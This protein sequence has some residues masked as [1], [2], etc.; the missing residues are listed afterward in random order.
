MFFLGFSLAII[1]ITVFFETH[2]DTR[3]V[4]LPLILGV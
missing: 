1:E 2:I 3:I 4:R